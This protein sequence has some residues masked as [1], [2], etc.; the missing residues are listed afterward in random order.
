[1][2]ARARAK[3]LLIILAAPVAAYLLWLGAA[4]VRFRPEHAPMA[5]ASAGGPPYEVE[6]VYHVH[7][8]YSDGRATTEKVA[9]IAARRSLDFI[10]LTDHGRPNDKSLASQGKRD[11]IFVLAGSEL[12]VSRGHLVA[13][14]FLPPA[15]HFSQKADLAVQEIAAAGG[16]SVVAHPYSKTPWT[17]GEDSDFQG[18]EIADSDSMVKKNY[19]RVIPY[20]PAFLIKPELV[21]LRALTRPVETL[22]KWDSLAARRPVY[23]YFSADA[24]MFYD[25]VFRFFRLHVLLEEPL[26]PEF[27]RARAQIFGALRSGHFYSAVEAAAAA[28]GFRFEAEARGATRPMGSVVTWDGGEPVRLRVRAP[29]AFATETRLIRNGRVIGQAEGADLSYEADT[30]GDYRVEVYLKGPS[31]LAADFPWIVA[32]PIFI[33]RS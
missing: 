6:G 32:N 29:F 30:V 3:R 21:L 17:W 16:F 7:T 13:L 33:K 1:M 31:P 20:L 27:E 25:A 2:T 23:G 12:S 4:V 26:A 10:I 9:A 15:G 19:A 18:I 28:R 22:R 5:P 24:H 11:G 8:K 14:D